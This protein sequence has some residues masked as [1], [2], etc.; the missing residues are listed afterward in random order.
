MTA[1]DTIAE[2]SEQLAKLIEERLGVR[3]RGLERKLQK[4]GRMLPRWV[5]QEAGRFVEAQRLMG[6]P[7]LMMQANPGALDDAFAR[8]ERWLKGVDPSERRKDRI[9][10]FLATNAFNLILIGALFIAYLNV[11]GHI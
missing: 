4:A 11:A 9:L 8:C 7:K 3:G 2:R 1:D 5:R 10:G 6:H